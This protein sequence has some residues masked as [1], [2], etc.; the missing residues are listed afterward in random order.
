MHVCLQFAQGLNQ[1]IACDV[2]ERTLVSSKRAASERPRVTADVEKAQAIARSRLHDYATSTPLLR[3]QP[4]ATVF[5]RY[6]YLTLP[7][8]WAGCY[9]V[10]T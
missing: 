4:S 6:P 1:L 3:L 2:Q 10:R 7:S 8:W 5:A 9:S